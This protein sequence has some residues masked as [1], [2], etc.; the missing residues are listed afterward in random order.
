MF[1][2]YCIIC[3]PFLSLFE[4]DY[5]CQGWLAMG[6]I[7]VVLSVGRLVKLDYGLAMHRFKKKNKGKLGKSE[8][9]NQNLGLQVETIFLI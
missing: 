2:S 4:K 6:P 9:Y 5:F 1:V 7:F 8:L 3:L